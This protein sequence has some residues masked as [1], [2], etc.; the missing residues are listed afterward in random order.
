MP[1]PTVSRKASGV[2]RNAADT[3]LSM[4]FGSRSETFLL[5]SNL[6]VSGPATRVYLIHWH[7][8]LSQV[9]SGNL[10]LQETEE[11][12]EI[13]TPVLKT[14]NVDDDALYALP[15]RCLWKHA[16]LLSVAH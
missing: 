2:S 1:G 12:F 6:L 3:G 15:R 5:Q 16:Q 10:P 7:R 4:L 13:L 8:L 14:V 9:L 11:R